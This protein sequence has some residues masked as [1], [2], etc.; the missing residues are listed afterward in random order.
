MDNHWSELQPSSIVIEC[1]R[2]RLIT[3]FPLNVAVP[4]NV[5]VLAKVAVVSTATLL[6]LR[7]MT[8]EPS[9]ASGRVVT[10]MGVSTPPLKAN[11]GK[12]AAQRSKKMHRTI[13]Q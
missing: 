12:G 9:T 13:W 7:F 3:T 2:D 11:D 4:V 8:S 1:V 10:P 6:L 5:V